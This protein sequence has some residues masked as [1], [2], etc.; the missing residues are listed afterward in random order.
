MKPIIKIGTW[1]FFSKGVVAM[2]LFPYIFLDKT[3]MDRLEEHP[4]TTGNAGIVLLSLVWYRV[5]TETD[6]IRERGLYDF[7]F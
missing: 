6:Y 4:P 3:Y 2:S 5:S 1:W 7:V